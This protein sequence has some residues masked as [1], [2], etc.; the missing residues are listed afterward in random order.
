LWKG[1]LGSRAFCKKGVHSTKVLMLIESTANLAIRLGS[2]RFTCCCQGFFKLI[3]CAYPAGCLGRRYYAA[4]RLPT[5][6][7]TFDFPFYHGAIA[8]VLASAQLIRKLSRPAPPSELPW[9]SLSRVCPDA[10]FSLRDLRAL[11][12][13]L[14]VDCATLRFGP[15]FG[16]SI[17]HLPRRSIDFPLG[18]ALSRGCSCA[19]LAKP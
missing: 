5:L 6:G 3:H 16:C 4:L 2:I 8:R 13:S 15:T 10:R 17:S 14:P 1:G 11:T 7:Y 9:G 18:Y 12:R 19:C